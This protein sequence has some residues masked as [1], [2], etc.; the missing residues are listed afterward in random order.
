FVSN[1]LSRRQPLLALHDSGGREESGHLS[2]LQSGAVRKWR[3]R[4]DGCR[5]D[6]GPPA[7]VAGRYGNQA[8]RSRHAGPRKSAPETDPYAPIFIGQLAV[9]PSL[10]WV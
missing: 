8:A 6:R 5:R 2:H 9:T 10:N 3:R 1:S 4:A 7:R